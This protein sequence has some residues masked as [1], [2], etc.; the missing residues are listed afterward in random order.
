MRCKYAKRVSMTGM[1]QISIDLK[2]S[3]SVSD[4]YINHKMDLTNLCKYIEEK[5]KDNP[6][7]TYFHAFMNQ[8]K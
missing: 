6:D 1:Q 4:V 3:R 5:K 8:K 2:P 7:I